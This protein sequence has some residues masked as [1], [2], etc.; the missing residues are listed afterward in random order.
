[1]DSI[2][3]VELDPGQSPSFGELLRR[4]RIAAG[5]TQEALADIA[6]DR[7]EHARAEGLYRESLALLGQATDA[8]S[9]AACL[10]GLAVAAWES[11][12]LE[13]AAELHGVAAA[14]RAAAD[15]P[16]PPP[17]R[18]R[19]EPVIAAIR[20]ALGDHR[21]DAARAR[22]QALSLEQAV[23]RAREDTPHARPWGERRQTRRP[24][25]GGHT[26]G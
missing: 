19:Y 11:G 18:A 21:F 6:R 26:K 8:L 13:R 17:D 5:L 15:T 25:E 1:M 9:V 24:R 10:E 22:G 4:H 20:A 14:L 23:A 2:R 3:P 12:E 7:G 16:L